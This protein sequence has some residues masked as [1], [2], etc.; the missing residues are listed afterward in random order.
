MVC[1]RVFVPVERLQKI[2]KRAKLLMCPRAYNAP[3]VVIGGMLARGQLR[4][5]KLFVWLVVPHQHF[6]NR[7]CH[8][9][10]E[11]KYR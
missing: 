4:G 3:Q 7:S 5:K 1:V 8:N 2:R 6:V 10:S 9:I 11:F